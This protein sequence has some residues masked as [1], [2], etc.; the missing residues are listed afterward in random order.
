LPDAETLERQSDDPRTGGR[1]AAL[2]EWRTRLRGGHPA[3]GQSPATIKPSPN[4]DYSGLCTGSGAA[5]KCPNPCWNGR[6][7]VYRNTAACNAFVERAINRARSTEDLAPVTLP[8]NWYSL[9]VP[10]QLFVLADLERT[11]RGLPRISG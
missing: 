1:F 5:F 11:A 8:T 6:G 9:T 10:E 7:V 3:S 4:F 2:H